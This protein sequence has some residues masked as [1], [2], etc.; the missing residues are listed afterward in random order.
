MKK[1]EVYK[2]INGGVRRG[3]LLVNSVAMFIAVISA[4]VTC[5]WVHYQPEIP[6]CLKKQENKMWNK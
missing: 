3:I 2:N 6:E 5:V 4:N 1:K